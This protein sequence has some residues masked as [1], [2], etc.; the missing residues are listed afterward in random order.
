MPKINTITPA[1]RL[2]RET[3]ALYK[4][5]MI[6]PERAFCMIRF[7]ADGSEEPD[8]L[9][10][11]ARFYNNGIGCEKN[12][13]LALDALR[14]SGKADW[15][16]GPAPVTWLNP[17]DD[18]EL[19]MDE[20]EMC[21]ELYDEERLVDDFLDRDDDDYRALY[22]R[23][24][25]ANPGC[26]ERNPIVIDRTADYWDDEEVALEIL[27]RL[28]PY[29]YVDYEVVDQHILSR[30]GRYIDHVTVRVSTHPLLTEDPDGD[31]YLP[32]RKVLGIEEYWFDLP[33][34]ISAFRENPWES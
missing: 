22:A 28:V 11:L 24:N 20:D 29:R 16:V 17:E 26:N 9:S 8:A 2:V 23:Y 3:I 6:T 5:G 4:G 15:L 30:D 10:E 25:P 21:V 1:K 33:G 7:A 13:E 27:L 19:S 12:E 34:N 18:T 31:I 14:R 32:A